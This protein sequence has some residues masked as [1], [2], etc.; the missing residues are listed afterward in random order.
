M[1]KRRSSL[2]LLAGLAVA[3]TDQ[4]GVTVTAGQTTT[5]DFALQAATRALEDAGLKAARRSAFASSRSRPEADQ[6][7][8]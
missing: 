3:F 1:M 2:T 6:R 5:A 8:S 7:S 4:R